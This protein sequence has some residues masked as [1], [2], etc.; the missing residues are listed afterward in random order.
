MLIVKE[1]MLTIMPHTNGK[2]PASTFKVGS[3]R[4]KGPAIPGER[5]ARRTRDAIVELIFP[6]AVT[7]NR[8]PRSETLI[9][10]VSPRWPV[11]FR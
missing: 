9:S 10:L 3:A 8:D 11:D 5:F 4:T 6:P 7:A 2:N 1:R